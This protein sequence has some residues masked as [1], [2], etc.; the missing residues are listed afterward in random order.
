[1]EHTTPARQQTSS[2]V[3][4]ALAGLGPDAS[5]RWPEERWRRAVNRVRAGRSLAPAT[6]PHGA[7]VAVALWF[8]VDQ[9]TTSLRDGR[10]S[11]ASLAQGE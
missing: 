1:M 6:W 3:E 10:T 4:G 7:Q 8:D 2:A 5:W 11:P 9:E